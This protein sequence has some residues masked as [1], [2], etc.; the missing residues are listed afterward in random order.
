M[1]TSLLK[2]IPTGNVLHQWPVMEFTKYDRNRLW[3]AVMIPAALLLVAYGMISNNFLFSLII[4]LAGIILFLHEHQEPM[5]VNF[6][7]TEL[8]IAIGNRFYPYDELT[9]F[10]IVY[11][12]PEVQTLFFETKN[13]LRPRI[14][15]PLDDRNPVDIRHTLQAFLPEDTDR[16]EEPMSDMV[17]RRWRLM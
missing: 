8:G 3:Y 14:R 1:P 11:Q 16:A 2:D 7:I 9:A 17:A 13:I 15:V 12:P 4:I 10:F 5:T 6:A